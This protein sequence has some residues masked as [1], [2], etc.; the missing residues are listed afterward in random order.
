MNTFEVER[1]LRERM[2]TVK[3]KTLRICV[4]LIALAP[5]AEAFWDV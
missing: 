5:G 2:V 4:D 1:R 3:N